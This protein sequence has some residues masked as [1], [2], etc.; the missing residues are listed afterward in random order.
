MEATRHDPLKAKVIR[1]WDAANPISGRVMYH[2][3]AGR[4]PRPP[5]SVRGLRRWEMIHLRRFMRFL[6]AMPRYDYHGKPI[7]IPHPTAIFWWECR[8]AR[9]NTA[10]ATHLKWFASLSPFDRYVLCDFEFFEARMQRERRKFGI[11]EFTANDRR[12]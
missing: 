10:D 4:Q 2:V 9:V 8:T 11:K 7:A 3:P 1:E 12:Y 5:Q 6:Q